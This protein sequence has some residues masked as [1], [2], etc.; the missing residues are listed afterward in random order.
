VLDLY[1]PYRRIQLTYQKVVGRVGQILLSLISCFVF[2]QY[3]TASITVSPVSYA[4]YR[5]VFF[6]LGPN[7]F[8][9]FTLLREFIFYRALNSKVA[10]IWMTLSATFIAFFPTW[11]SA[12]SGYG[13]KRGAFVR[14]QTGNFAKTSDIR[15]IDYII[16]DGDR[17]GL[18]KDYV[19]SGNTSFWGSNCKALFDSSFKCKTN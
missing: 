16:H 2:A 1:R 17:I 12:M 19:I 5:T 4:T 7:T 15:Y 3:V 11:V 13:G 10:M 8:S 14:D 18:T 9:I 6:R